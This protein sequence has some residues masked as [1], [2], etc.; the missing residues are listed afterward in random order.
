MSVDGGEHV[1]AVLA[2][3]PTTAALPSISENFAFASCDDAVTSAWLGIMLAT[4]HVHPQH[5]TAARCEKRRRNPLHAHGVQFRF[6][7]FR[8][9]AKSKRSQTFLQLLACTAVAQTG[10]NAASK[11]RNKLSAQ[12][13]IFRVSPNFR[14]CILATKTTP[15]PGQPAAN[16]VDHWAI[17]AVW[18]KS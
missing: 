11:C 15:I 17:C 8:L 4:E 16:T 14:L 9:T 5:A 2:M 7:N 6:D 3:R 10:Y 13:R 1:Q 18:A 12:L